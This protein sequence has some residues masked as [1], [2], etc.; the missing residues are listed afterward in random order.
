MAAE[1][2]LSVS[3]VTACRRF[4]SL[5]VRARSHC[6]VMQQAGCRR[7]LCVTVYVHVATRLCHLTR[8]RRAR[9]AR[10]SATRADDDEF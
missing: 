8:G 7:C 3:R 6:Y 9:C 10:E 2:P 5:R 4:A 1:R